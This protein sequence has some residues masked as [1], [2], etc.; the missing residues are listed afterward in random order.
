[1]RFANE[2]LPRDVENAGDETGVEMAKITYIEY[3][4]TRHEID[5]PNGLTVMEG[6]RDNNIPGIEADC[7]GCCACSTCHVYVDE[8]WVDKLPKKDVM[9]EDMLDFA[10]EPDVTR[11]R[12]TCQLTVTDQLDGLI[13]QMPK[14]QI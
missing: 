4:G 3:G 9:E 7:G 13:V 2:P 5:V 14:R 12:L 6:A 10:W 11:S 8:A 1:M